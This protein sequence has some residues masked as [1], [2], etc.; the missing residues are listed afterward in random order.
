MKRGCGICSEDVFEQLSAFEGDGFGVPCSR[1]CV[2]ILKQIEKDVLLNMPVEE[3][4]G[5][6]YTESFQTGVA[7]ECG[8]F[9]VTGGIKLDM[10][11]GETFVGDMVAIFANYVYIA[12]LY[13][14][15]EKAKSGRASRLANELEVIVQGEVEDKKGDAVRQMCCLEGTLSQFAGY[16][17]G[18]IRGRDVQ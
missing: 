17:E 3:G 10:T 4:G 15:E 11:T 9:S 8:F 16:G 5:K 18:S 1:L 2:C 12:G 7:G 14:I 6:K 13:L